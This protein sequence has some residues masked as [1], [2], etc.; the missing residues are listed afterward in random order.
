MR[1]LLRKELH[2][3]LHPTAPLFLALSAM[4][5]IPSYPYLVA[6]FY[7]GLAIFFTCLNGRENQ[8]VAYTLL[9]PVSKEDVVRARFF[10]VILLETAQLLTAL[11]FVILRQTVLTEPN[12]AGMDANLA[13][14]GLAL[15]QMG[16][17]NL[18][19]FRIYYRNVIRVGAAFL[20]AGGA[21]FLFITAAEASTHILPFVRDV[22][23]TPDPRHLTA[24]LA[25]LAAGA[26]AYILMT[27]QAMRR[28]VKDFRRQDL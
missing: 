7:T 16:L 28:A 14:I 13:L 9:L 26:G 2:L 15:M 20:W 23:D 10:M 25:V 11:P 21:V 22:L 27:V 17:F 4:L 18:T 6:F 8:D 3:A 1:L 12:P 24:K 5:L 19:F